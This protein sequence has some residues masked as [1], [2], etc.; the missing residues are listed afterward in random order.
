MKKDVLTNYLA[1]F[2]LVCLV[3]DG[4]LLCCF[5]KKPWWNNWMIMAPNLFM[6]L[7]AFYCH[8]LLKNAETNSNPFRWLFVYKSIKLLL[9]TAGMVLYIVYVKDNSKAFIFVTAISYFVSLV[10]ETV[11]YAMP[12]S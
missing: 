8:L 10:T 3:L 6:V 7:G 4:I 12:N 2:L 9:T 1:V 11:I 5:T